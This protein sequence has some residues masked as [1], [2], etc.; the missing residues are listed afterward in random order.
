MPAV[1]TNAGLFTLESSQ[2]LKQYR[3]GCSSILWAPVSSQDCYV[4]YARSAHQNRHRLC[5]LK[6]VISNS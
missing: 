5:I 2:T 1:F 6:R 3:H 4:T